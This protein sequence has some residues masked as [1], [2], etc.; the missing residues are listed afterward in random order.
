MTA[1]RRAD[2]AESGRRVSEE[3]RE[4]EVDRRGEEE[5]R[6]NVSSEAPEL[7]WSASDDDS[8]TDKT[9]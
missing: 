5:S 4:G 2:S 8:P 1:E 3:V 7:S 9:V 6:I